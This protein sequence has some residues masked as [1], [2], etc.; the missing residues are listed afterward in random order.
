MRNK[1]V[2]KAIPDHGDLDVLDPSP[3]SDRYGCTYEHRHCKRAVVFMSVIMTGN[4][5]NSYSRLCKV[6]QESGQQGLSLE[7]HSRLCV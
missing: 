2:A 4:A 7:S 3:L 1:M 6:A 5:Q